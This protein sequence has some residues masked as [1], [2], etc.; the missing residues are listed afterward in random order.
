MR[1]L[2]GIIDLMDMSL[3]R[4]QDLMMDRETWGASSEIALL[5]HLFFLHFYKRFPLHVLIFPNF[6]WKFDFPSGLA[7]KNPRA[8]QKMLVRSL[9]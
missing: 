4:L 7:I 9:G 5:P 2:D 1:W 3:S 8:M 6:M